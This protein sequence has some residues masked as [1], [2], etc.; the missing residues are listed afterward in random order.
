L[1]TTLVCIQIGTMTTYDDY[2]TVL[3]DGRIA[4]GHC[5]L[6]STLVFSSALFII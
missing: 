1:H 2:F 3:V 5:Q 4:E 6:G